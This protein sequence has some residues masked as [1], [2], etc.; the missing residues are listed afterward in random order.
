MKEWKI[1]RNGSM[2]LHD[3][4]AA[5]LAHYSQYNSGLPVAVRVNPC[6]LEAAT[7]HVKTM[8]AQLP[9]ESNAGVASVETWLEVL[10]VKNV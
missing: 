4:I 3:R 6:D 10:E 2:T 1:Y 8:G 7:A 9:V 5:A